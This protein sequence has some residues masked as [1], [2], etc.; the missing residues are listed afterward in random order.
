LVCANNTLQNK[1]IVNI[2]S[3]VIL[4]GSGSN[5]LMYSPDGI[6]YTALGNSTFTTSCRTIAWNGNLWVAGGEGIN[7]LAYSY[8][9][10]V[11]TGLGNTVFQTACYKIAF[12]GSNWV[13][14]GSGGNTIAVSTNGKTW[15]GIG[16]PVFDLSG[17]AVDWNGSYWLAGGRAT[18]ATNVLAYTSDI[19]GVNNWTAVSPLPAPNPINTIK[20]MANRWYVGGVGTTSSTILYAATSGV[21]N[22]NATTWTPQAI[23]PT[24]TYTSCVSLEWSGTEILQCANGPAGFTC[25]VRVNDSSWNNITTVASY[26]ASVVAFTGKRYVL[27]D[28]NGSAG[29]SYV[30]NQYRDTQP[31]A[32]SLALATANYIPTNISN[33]TSTFTAL[34]VGTNDK[35]GAYV[36]SSRMYLN[37]G[38][39]LNV[40]GPSTYDM[41]LQQ[42]TSI[43]FNLNAPV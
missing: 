23:S 13:G 6:T 10:K 29:H 32:G 12:N 33:G 31:V 24:S 28:S 43:S 11:W 30:F 26:N 5:T 4:G 14:V 40:Y 42:D 37:A 15:T 22:P 19:Y 8:D 38:D 2:N 16:K 9:G 35:L 41:A 21:L 36:P 18:S 7:T 20:W 1:S 17:L 27:F 39:S 25:T 34:C 3:A